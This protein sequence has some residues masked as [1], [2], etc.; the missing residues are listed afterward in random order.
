M[1][2]KYKTQ[3]GKLI[4]KQLYYLSDIIYLL[5]EK[6]DLI[7]IKKISIKNDY[8]VKVGS[9]LGSK[10][11]Q[12]I[13]IYEPR[14]ELI[15]KILQSILEVVDIY[16][17]EG[18]LKQVYGFK[19]KNLEHWITDLKLDPNHGNIEWDI[20]KYLSTP[21][22][23]QCEFCLH[24]SDPPGYYTNSGKWKGSIKEIEERI[25]YF[26]PLKKKALFSEFT[27]GSYEIISHPKLFEILEKIRK[28]TDLPISVQT[29]GSEL[30]EE[31]ID[32]LN[33]Y[34]PIAIMVSLNSS[35]KMVRK[36]AMKD[37]NPDTSID[38]LAYLQ[39]QKIPYLISLTHWYKSPIDELRE[40]II[41]VDKF[42]PYLIRMNLEAYSKYHP[43]YDKYNLYEHWNRI[44][45]LVRELREKVKTPI[46]FQPVL[47]EEMIYGEEL[48]PIIKGVIKN[49]PAYFAG[50]KVGDEILKINN[51]KVTYRETVKQVLRYLEKQTD[52]Y[53]LEILR[54]KE[55]I[56]VNVQ[57][58]EE[59]YPNNNLY[60]QLG[61]SYPW[62]IVLSDSLNPLVMKDFF[63][64]LEKYREVL[65]ISSYLVQ[66]SF[67]KM[68]E[69]M[70]ENYKL[71]TKVHV[72]I[73]KNYFLGEKVI[74]GDLL[75]VDDFI[76]CINKWIE[77][78]KKKPD[79][80]IIPSTPFS[81][82]GKDITGKSVRH[83]ERKTKIP[84]KILKTTRIQALGG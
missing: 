51:K 68:Y 81:V 21:C 74:I 6:L 42:E 79:L 65:L 2:T 22:K 15:Y 37:I 24:K 38:S 63:S 5:D 20:L 4:I 61:V 64:I 57:K 77:K 75:T 32:K 66:S 27:Y 70:N 18:N 46:V 59:R 55:K 25:K 10:T 14:L 3:L 47:Y 35:N 28:K 71:K 33:K 80:V 17:Y 54:E 48:K 56:I 11:M 49:S 44:V 58:T 82:W 7:N 36:E 29:N 73:P 76:L 31:I 52:K 8:K 62:G 26:D 30:D 53:L 34:S 45:N 84:V 83:I 40:T 23:V 12:Q 39:K 67:K 19:L 50:L 78:N 1:A 16:D 41:F 43:L 13:G 9:N 72:A 69:E 60:K